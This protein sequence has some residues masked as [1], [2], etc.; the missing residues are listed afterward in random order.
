[1]EYLLDKPRSRQRIEIIPD[2]NDDWFLNVNWIEKKTEKVVHTS[3]I[4]R[5]DLK[6]W[7]SY[8]EGDTG[9]NW[10]QKPIEA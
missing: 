10:K 6:G 2:E 4:I 5:G 1:M 3:F 9:G 8:L 7:L